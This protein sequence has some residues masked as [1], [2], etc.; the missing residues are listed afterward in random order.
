M[1][2][3][4]GA[5]TALAQ[6]I[7]PDKKEPRI[8]RLL[9]Q[10]DQEVG[11]A[12]RLMSA[13]NFQG[14]ADVLEV[15]CQKDPDDRLAHNL[16]KNCYDFLKQ[17]EK[18]ELLIRSALERNPDS[19][20][21]WIALGEVLIKAGKNDEGAKAFDEVVRLAWI[22]NDSRRLAAIRSLIASGFD[23]RA[24]QLIQDARQKSENSTLFATERGTVLEGQMKY[25][26]AL[27][28]YMSLLSGE[29]SSEAVQAE[30]KLLA[31]LEFEQSAEEVEAALVALA[32]SLSSE[33][34]L[35]LLMNHCIKVGR[36]EDAF[37]FAVRQDSVSSRKAAP[38]LDFM[39][40]CEERKLWDE[41]PRVAEY[42][43]SRYGGD[44][45]VEVPTMFR[46]AYALAQ[47]GRAEDAI[48]AYERLHDKCERNQ[49]KA[50]ALYSIG[51]VHLDL[52]GDVETA[53]S[54]FDSIVTNYPVGS[55]YVNSRIAIPRC[56]LRAGRLD[57]AR[58]EFEGLG[59]FKLGEDL[60]EEISYYLG[61]VRFFH[62]SYDSSVVAFRKL[63][64]DYPRGYYVNDALQ[65]VL[66]IGE[67]KQ[68]DTALYDLSSA[69][70]FEMRKMPDSARARLQT[71]AESDGGV[72]ADVALF[73]L[74]NLEIEQSNSTAALSA[75]EQLIAN[76][77]DS[78]YTPYGLKT[79]ADML[80]KTDVG[81]IEAGQIYRLLLET[82]P[83][84]PFA[85]EIRQK[86]REL[87]LEQTIG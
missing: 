19:F 18:A 48:S 86:L 50:E 59:K 44:V 36:F 83:D 84:Y 52:L 55:A 45:S 78:Y 40:R 4:A 33:R 1:M 72:L 85:S 13:G 76:F 43:V 15:T 9:P 38:L 71:I 16:L 51:A 29:N 26:E 54:Y 5:G 65:M 31:L 56:H 28:E 47:L 67:G 62:K 2:V 32:D 3:A 27:E 66:L 63:M 39:R 21:D 35:S 20:G 25:L 69:M 81:T 73:R 79:K 64:V 82:Y 12:R 42:V 23:D 24:L 87:E 17:F 11:L 46:Y 74:A 37:T 30:K 70:F 10:E 41:V 80:L 14:A 68:D 7:Q 34:V 61:M 22:G 6:S 53:L 8:I 49:E 60:T 57:Q 75:I 58:A 77:P